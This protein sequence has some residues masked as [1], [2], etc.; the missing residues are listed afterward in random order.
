MPRSEIGNLTLKIEPEALRTIIS[1]GRLLEFVDTA[2]NAARAQI[3]AQIVQHLAQASLDKAGAAGGVAVDFALLFE[4]GDY[5]TRPPRPHFG[6][7]Q[8]G[9]PEAGALSRIAGTQGAV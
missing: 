4:G 6:V 7:V 9:D 2:A 3:A 1:E 5:G 8:L